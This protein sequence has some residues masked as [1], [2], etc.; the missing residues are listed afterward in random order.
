M[1]S[2]FFKNP[3]TDPDYSVSG[4]WFWNDKLE[5]EVLEEQLGMMKR[6]SANQPVIH[7][8]SGR[9]VDYLGEE[10]FE[11]IQCVIQ[12]AKRNGQRIWLYDEDNWPS[13]N[14]S[15]RLTKNEELREHFLQF[16]HWTVE[17]GETFTLSIAGRCCLNVT[18]VFDGGRET[19]LLAL[20]TEGEICWTA[21]EAAEVDAVF[22]CVDDYE[23]AGKFSIDY[24]SKEAIG[25]FL[26]STHEKYRERFAQEFGATIAGMFMDETRFCNAMPWTKRLPEEFLRRKGYDLPPLLHLLRRKG[27]RASMVRFDYYDVISDLYA[28]ATCGTIYDWCRENNLLATGHF[29]G[30]ETLCAQSYFGA[31]VCR[32]Y[33][34]FHIPGIDHL[35]NGVGS[36]QA[37]FAVSA[38]HNYGK[39]RISCEGF[40]GAGWDVGCE[41][42]IRMTNWLIQQGVNLI[43]IHGFYYSVREERFRDWPPSYFFQWK[44]WDKMPAYTAMTNRMM[45]MIS[46]GMR[47]EEILVYSPMETLW[48]YFDPDLDRKT[49][50]GMGPWI[51]DPRA[52][53]L[54]HEFQVLCGRLADE[55]L[56]FNILGSDAVK[57]FQ[58]KDGKLVNR[59]S[60]QEFSLFVLPFTEVLTDETVRLL[61]EFT[62]SGGTVISLDS[63][64]DL[65]VSKDGGHIRGAALPELDASRFCAEETIS[66]VIALCR[67]RLRLPFRILSGITGTSHSQ[68]AYPPRI[69]DPYMHDGERLFGIAVSRYRRDGKRLFHLTNYNMQEE[70][71]SLWLDSQGAPE[72]WAPETG[73]IYTPGFRTAKDGGCLLELSL[74]ANRSLFIVC[75]L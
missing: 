67:E 10:W 66:G 25:A 63:R 1:N 50:F 37:K 5:D 51:P 45:E 32:G 4:F 38:A 56:D 26:L 21:E 34:Y 69:I 57:N 73:E 39:T 64:V 2:E 30:E 70:R 23:G 20:E 33:Q 53:Q 17:K 13:G 41:D 29:L 14:C 60:G 27:R 58:V 47:E 35:G 40:G 31:D 22:C 9:L 36:L 72:V 19:G 55:N 24:L 7:S 71:V 75:D 54:D 28:E 44:D 43:M 74:P 65:V 3:V 61:N 52:A 12:A 46:E 8:R 68:L 11:K 62:A 42:L 59:L 6:I 48:K 18:A 16:E 15:W 49:G